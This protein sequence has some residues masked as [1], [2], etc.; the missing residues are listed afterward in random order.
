MKV[1]IG[2]V[3]GT[4]GGP[5]TYALALLRALVSLDDGD[6]SYAL[7][8]DDPAA[9]PDIAP[10]ERLRMPLP[11]KAARPLAEAIALPLLA[12]RAGLDA[13]HATKQTLPRGLGCAGLVSIHDLAPML[14]PETFPRAGGAWLRRST[15]SAAARADRVLTGSETT[16]RDLQA[17]LGVPASRIAVR[18]TGCAPSSDPPRP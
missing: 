6:E 12:R 16:A 13:F 4:R 5:R 15:A 9:E 2:A 1:G 3:T 14:F 17:H 7:L 8:A 10:L 11:V 18:R